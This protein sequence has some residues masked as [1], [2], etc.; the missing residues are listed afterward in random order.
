MSIDES[1]SIS[2]YLS[3]GGIA[4]TD[5]S[6]LAGAILWMGAVFVGEL[7]TTVEQALALAALVL[8]P[9]GMGM[10]AT[11]PFG[12]VSRRPYRAAVLGQPV[13]AF[14]FLV[15]LVLPS[16]GP[17]AAVAAV[18]WVVVTGLLGLAA[19]ARTHDR[20]PWPLSETVIDAGFAYSIVGA[21][22]LVL[23]Q[24]DITFWFEPIIILLT[25]V[26]FHFAG[27]VLPVLT[28]LAGRVL[29]DRAG[30]EF[31][32]LV[33]VI[34]FGPAFIAIGISFSPVVE[35]LAVGGFTVAIAVL[36][37]YITIRIVPGR[38]R[39]QGVLV[40]VSSL[41]LPV[42]MLLALGYGI[43]TFTEANLLGLSISRMITLHGVLNAYGF[44][45]LGTVGWRLAVPNAN[46]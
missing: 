20:G 12:E 14:F 8:V 34:L 33:G 23:Y 19:L 32:V 22:A 41:V 38:P 17:G 36:G 13:G 42:S 31:R 27:F 46:G 18:P 44:A 5:V 9:L 16:D 43:G 2:G 39:L 26:H 29:G 4:V 45:L 35:V 25:A 40:A 28:G 10:A 6:S 3:A 24:L 15:S 37:G 30:T 11:P 21:V 7:A 1:A